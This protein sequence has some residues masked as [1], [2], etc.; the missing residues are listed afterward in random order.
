M[1]QFTQPVKSKSYA[2]AGDQICPFE[3]IVVSK[4]VELPQMDGA[5]DHE[6]VAYKAVDV[7]PGRRFGVPLPIAGLLITLAIAIMGS[8]TLNT[9]GQ[10]GRIRD[11]IAQLQNSYS[12]FEKERMLLSEE[13]SAAKDSNFI[14]YYASQNLGMKLALHEQTIQVAAASPSASSGDWMVG[15]GVLS[16]RR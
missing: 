12:S 14:C 8:I 6:R 2:V 7:K 11:E 15:I 16:G 10:S 13:L 5:D 3:R 1:T 4:H 9:A